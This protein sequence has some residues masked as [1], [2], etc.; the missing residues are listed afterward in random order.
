MVAAIITAVVMLTVV[1][2]P[3]ERENRNQHIPTDT[4]KM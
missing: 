3:D 4:E 2:G 1:D